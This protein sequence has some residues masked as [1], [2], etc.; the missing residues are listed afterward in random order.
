MSPLLTLYDPRIQIK[1][2]FGKTHIYYKEKK[3]QH[4]NISS[5]LFLEH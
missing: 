5:Q 3:G 1:I 2:K 4:D